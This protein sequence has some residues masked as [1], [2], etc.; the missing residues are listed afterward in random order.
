[1]LAVFLSF[2]VPSDVITDN[3]SV[4]TPMHHHESTVARTVAW[5]SRIPPLS[6][7]RYWFDW[8]SS[9]EYTGSKKHLDWNHLER[10]QLPGN[11]VDQMVHH[12][13]NL[14]NSWTGRRNLAG[15][16]EE[17]W[18]NTQQI[19]EKTMRAART[20]LHSL[21]LDALWKTKQR[22]M[23]HWYTSRHSFP[24][25]STFSRRVIECSCSSQQTNVRLELNDDK[26]QYLF[27]RECC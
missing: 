17:K 4:F 2:L 10:G 23:M 8:S 14:G 24:T 6:V 5:R 15:R 18:E 13:H 12:S 20:S 21:T 7:R 19:R 25:E 1:M 22:D 11:D 9:F 16:K 27:K 3:L 26:H